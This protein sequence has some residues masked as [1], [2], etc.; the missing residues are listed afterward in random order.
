VDASRKKSRIDPMD[1]A[2]D[3]A[4]VCPYGHVA[5]PAV[6]ENPEKNKEYC[7]DRGEKP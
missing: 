5:N 4:Q 2:Y 7:E 6:Q 3:E 1:D